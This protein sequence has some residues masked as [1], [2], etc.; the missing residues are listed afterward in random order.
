MSYTKRLFLCLS[1][2]VLLG[3]ALLPTGQ[4]TAQVCAAGET[5]HVIQLGEN[6]FRISLRY[7]VSMNAIAARNGIADVRRIYAGDVLCIPGRGTIVTTTTTTTNQTTTTTTPAGTPAIGSSTD[8]WCYPGRPWGDGRC[9]T[10]DPAVTSYNWMAGWAMAQVEAGRLDSVPAFL[11]PTGVTLVLQCTGA[12]SGTIS[13][14]LTAMGFP[15]GTYG[16]NV[17]EGTGGT[18]SG[19][20]TVSGSVGTMSGFI[21]STALNSNLTLDSP[22]LIAVTNPTINNC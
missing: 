13:Y 18:A 16:Y 2:M 22:S 17:N 19:V 14:T 3:A 12:G 11:Q 10:S 15:D 6:L 1:M 7:G 20:L 4:A 9:T 5:T 8:N 21:S